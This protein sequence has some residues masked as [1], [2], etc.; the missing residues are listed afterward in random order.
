MYLRLKRLLWGT[1]AGE[2]SRNGA[3]CEHSHDMEKRLQRETCTSK[4]KSQPGWLQADNATPGNC[5]WSLA[6]PPSIR[7]S[8]HPEKSLDSKPKRI[9]LSTQG[10]VTLWFSPPQRVAENKNTSLKR[11]EMNS[12]RIAPGAQTLQPDGQSRA[13]APRA[14]PKHMLPAAGRSW[15]RCSSARANTVIFRQPA[16]AWQPATC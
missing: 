1:E 6:V 14:W 8:G 3:R 11:D 15:T 12:P 5:K 16:Q 13:G 10:R 4:K 7:A 2:S 9:S